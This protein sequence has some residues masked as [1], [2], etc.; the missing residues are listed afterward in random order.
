MGCSHYIVCRFG[1]SSEYRLLEH[2]N[3]EENANLELTALL[4]PC[5]PS[6]GIGSPVAKI[7][8]TLLRAEFHSG[9]LWCRAPPDYFLA[10]Q[11]NS[12]S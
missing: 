1:L 6:P 12:P 10:D 5:R 8:K 7:Q 3:S 11:Q 4:R 2:G 9:H